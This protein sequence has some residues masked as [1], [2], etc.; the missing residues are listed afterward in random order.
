LKS[1]DDSLIYTTL[2]KKTYLYNEI[3]YLECPEL[4]KED[5]E[6]NKCIQ[7]YN[8]EEDI[9]EPISYQNTEEVENCNGKILVVDNNVLFSIIFLNTFIIFIIFF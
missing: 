2:S 8:G 6:N 4:L 5:D 7:E 9:I 1:C 3:C